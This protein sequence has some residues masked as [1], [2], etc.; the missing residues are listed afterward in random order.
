MDSSLSLQNNIICKAFCYGIN[1]KYQSAPH[2]MTFSNM[3]FAFEHHKLQGL[4]II[5]FCKVVVTHEFCEFL[6]FTKCVHV[7]T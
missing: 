1:K 4:A 3:S 5:K 6:Y 2:D 7:T